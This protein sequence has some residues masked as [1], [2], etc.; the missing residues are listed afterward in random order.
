MHKVY[1]QEWGETGNIKILP[2]WLC[3]HVSKL[4]YYIKYAIYFDTKAEA[5]WIYSFKC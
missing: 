1:F 2:S 3:T 4:I 5:I